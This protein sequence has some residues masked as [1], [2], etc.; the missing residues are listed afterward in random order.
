MHSSDSLVTGRCFV[1]PNPSRGR[2]TIHYEHNSLSQL[3]SLEIAIYSS[4]GQ[5]VRV[6]KPALN[7]NSYVVAVDWDMQSD[8]G[9]PVAD[10]VYMVRITAL[11]KDG[12]KSRSHTKIVKIR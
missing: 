11:S 2:T 3:K 8:K 6:I 4:S 12:S 5:V 1:Y 7:E 9:T 10:G